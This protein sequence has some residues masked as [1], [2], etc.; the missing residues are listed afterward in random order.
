MAETAIIPFR[1]PARRR[2]HE[3]VGEQLRDAILDGRY[4]AGS[5]LPPERE[6][7]LEFQVNRTSIREAIKVLESSGLIA[8]RQGDGATVQPIV[9]ASLDLI[10][11]MIFHRGRVNRFAAADLYEVA[12]PLCFELGRLAIERCRPE[13]VAEI[14][15]IRDRIADDSCNRDGRFAAAHDLMVALADVTGNRIWQMLARKLRAML[16]SSPMRQAR[17][18]LREEPGVFVPL[19]EPGFFVPVLDECI[20]GVER[21]NRDAAAAALRKF[22]EMIGS[23]NFTHGNDP[24]HPDSKTR[25]RDRKEAK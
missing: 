17:A 13:D 12:R 16:E 1:P 18:R 6:L 14:R 24:T 5:K 20:N 25:S 9:E 22:F 19:V 11:P 15:R 4:P 3:D 10:A 23:S 7:A 8:V 2:I 21:G